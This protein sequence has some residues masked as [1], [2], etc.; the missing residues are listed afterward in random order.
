MTIRI[1]YPSAQSRA[2]VK[3]GKIVD[4]NQWDENLRGYGPIK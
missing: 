3:D 4:M 2:I 1:P